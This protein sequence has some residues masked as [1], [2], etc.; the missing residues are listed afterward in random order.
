MKRLLNVFMIVMLLFAGQS[1]SK[2]GSS[3]S[4]DDIKEENKEVSSIVGDW[5]CVDMTIQQGP[6]SWTVEQYID[7]LQESID[8]GELSS[9]NADM[10][11]ENIRVLRDLKPFY[12]KQF[13]MSFFD[14]NK[15]T[16]TYTEDTDKNEAG[17]WLE[18]DEPDVFKVVFGQGKDVK[19]VILNMTKIGKSGYYMWQNVIKIHLEKT[20]KE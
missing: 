8:G 3:E 20:E 19:D 18:T 13:G 10:Y 11:A 12:I 5:D 14:D 17:N 9:E 4:S 1:C 16:S 2:D 7:Y 15:C 6:Y